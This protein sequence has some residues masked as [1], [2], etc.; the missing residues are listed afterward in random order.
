MSAN[1]PVCRSPDATENR[2]IHEPLL[3]IVSGTGFCRLPEP[4]VGDIFLDFEG[5]PFVGDCGLQYMFGFAS[6][7]A[8]GKLTYQNRWALNGEQEKLAF[9]WLVDE[10]MLRR[11]ED[12]GMHVYHFGAYEPTTLKRLMGI[13]ATREN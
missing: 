12:P 10:I 2:L 5:D 9:E 6:K 3:P 7:N 1:K 4:S 11:K 13:H 8:T